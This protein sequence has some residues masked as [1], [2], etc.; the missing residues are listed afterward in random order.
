MDVQQIEAFRLRH[1]HHFHG[2]R[3]R[4]GRVIEQGITRNFHFMKL[5][6]FVRVRK[7][8]GRRVA[9][10]VN[11]MPAR[12]KFHSKFRGHHARAAIRWVTC[13][14]DF[15]LNPGKWPVC[16]SDCPMKSYSPRNSTRRKSNKLKRK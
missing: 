7:P 12:C 13:D 3:K 14:P 9:D 4:V 5:D 15:H 6:S 16:S 10:E 8:D 1:L 2:Q 11:F